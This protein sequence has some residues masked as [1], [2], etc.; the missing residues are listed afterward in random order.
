MSLTKDQN[1]S[2]QVLLLIKTQIT[3][4]QK[5]A[6]FDWSRYLVRA[7]KPKNIRQARIT[8]IIK[9]KPRSTI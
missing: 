3:K 8:L 1:F 9:P 5:L 6:K 2:N 4:I 7:T